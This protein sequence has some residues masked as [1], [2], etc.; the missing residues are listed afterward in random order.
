MLAAEKAANMLDIYLLSQF[1][2]SSKNVQLMETISP[3][4][5]R[6]TATV[7]YVVGGEHDQVVRMQQY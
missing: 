5:D 2:A 7:M 6:Q 1:T 4:P 3:G